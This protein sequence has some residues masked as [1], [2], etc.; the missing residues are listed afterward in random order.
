MG[1]L[2]ARRSTPSSSKISIWRGAVSLAGREWAMIGA[3][4]RRW[5]R[6]A[7]RWTFSTFSVTP[8]S[9]AAHLMNAALIVVPWIP[10]SMSATNRSAIWSGLRET[11]NGGRW[12]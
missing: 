12:S 4:V 11:K 8:G 2:D 1:D 7:A 6:A 9:S 10:S 5:A 3:P